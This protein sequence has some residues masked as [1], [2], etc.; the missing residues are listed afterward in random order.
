MKWKIT[1]KMKRFFCG[2]ALTLGMLT[3]TA[4]AQLV[5]TGKHSAGAS[6]SFSV[7]LE[8][9]GSAVRQMVVTDLPCGEDFPFGRHTFTLVFNPTLAVVEG[10]FSARALS[11][12][13]SD[14]AHTLDIDGVLFDADGDGAREQAL[15]GVSF[16]SGANRCNFRWWATRV[17]IDNDGDGW[18][19]TAERRLGSNPGTSSST[20]EHREA[21]TTSIYGP[22][23]YRDYQDNDRDQF[24]DGAEPDG[25][26]ADTIP[27]CASPLPLPQP[28]P[29]DFTGRHSS[30]GG[31]SFALKLSSDN[32]ALIQIT[33]Y[34]LECGTDFPFG[35]HTFTLDLNP[36]IPI[37]ESKFSARD[38]P[39]TITPDPGHA[40]L[41]DIDGVVFDADGDGT[42]E[43]ALGGLS[44]LSGTNRCNF[45]WWVSAVATDTDGDGWSDTAERRLGSNPSTSS[46]TPEH[47]AVPTTFIFGLWPCSDFEDN[48]RD[49]KIDIE[50][51]DGPDLDLCRDCI[52]QAAAPTNLTASPISSSQID[53]TWRDN[54]A[55]ETGF[56]IER[57]TEIGTFNLIATA[58][59][60]ITMFADSGLSAGTTYFYR[61]RAIIMSDTCST[62]SYSN[63]AGVTTTAV[64]ER[65]SS[66]P[67]EFRL[68]Q[69]FPNPFNPSTT[70]DYALPRASH[71]RLTILD[72]VGNEVTVL[73]NEKKAPGRHQAHWNASGVASGVYWCR[74]QAGEFVETRKMLLMR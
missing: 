5:Y 38:I 8:T 12:T 9:N 28:S 45:R 29:V 32:S 6:N 24:I 62:S 50:D 15:G 51:L 58:S 2:G 17:A 64:K 41:L 19:D 49:G 16:V 67:T 14:H 3:Q 37:M 7:E 27:D 13:I 4:W 48:D 30:A 42:M 47:Q 61:V 74:V 69:N 1:T 63:E 11:I 33:A 18:S 35:R 66:V 20:P 46:S 44:F 65:E 59:A 36:A 68:S 26:D 39:L 73:V 43:Q 22:G 40:H 34:H 21:P 57:K 60:N 23:P 52:A 56:Q 10:R 71:V 70:I 54:S 25:P 53:L 55:N 72:L 31:S